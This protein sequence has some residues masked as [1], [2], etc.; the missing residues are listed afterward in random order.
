[1][2]FSRFCDLRALPLSTTHDPG[3]LVDQAEDVLLMCCPPPPE[4]RNTCTRSPRS[5]SASSISGSTA[6]VRRR[7]W[8]RPPDSVSGTRCTR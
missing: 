5:N 7:L 2:H 6:T 1:M 4:E 8:T 3:R